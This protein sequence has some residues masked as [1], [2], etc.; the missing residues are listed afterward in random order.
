[1]KTPRMKREPIPRQAL[2]KWHRRVVVE[3]RIVLST[4]LQD[5]VDAAGSVV[6]RSPGA[7]GDMP[8]RTPLRYTYAR[9]AGTLT[10]TTRGP[11]GASSGVQVNSLALSAFAATA[12]AEHIAKATAR[13][14]SKILAS[15][16][17]IVRGLAAKVAP[18]CTT[19]DQRGLTGINGG[20]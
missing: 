8:M 19:P 9:C 11:V 15:R 16:P 4:L 7:D 20:F 14:I 18:Q 3:V 5:R 2:H 13:K 17:I 6:A 1:V 12:A 10:M